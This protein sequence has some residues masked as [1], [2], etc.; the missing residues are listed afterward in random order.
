L[1]KLLTGLNGVLVIGFNHLIVYPIYRP[2]NRSSLSFWNGS[3]WINTVVTSPDGTNWTQTSS[4]PGRGLFGVTYG[5]KFVAVGTDGQVLYSTNGF[6]WHTASSG[7]GDWLF[8][9]CYG[10]GF[11][12]AV[13]N[14]GGPYQ[15]PIYISTD[16]INWSSRFS[17]AALSFDSVVFGNDRF[18]TVGARGM[19]LESSLVPGNM[20]LH[21][22]WQN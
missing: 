7:T 18:V 17:N 20:D 21:I 19:I 2:S 11:Y 4:F 13:G 15:A 3:Q 16:G 8:D 5:G 14:G 12:V 22:G 6:D 9:V 1:V 10:D